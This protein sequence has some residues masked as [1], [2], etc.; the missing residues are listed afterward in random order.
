[1]LNAVFFY[2][3]KFNF[4]MRILFYLGWLLL[5]S[6]FLWWLIFIIVFLGGLARDFNWTYVMTIL[7]QIGVGAYLIKNF[8]S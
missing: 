4:S 3:I 7:I 1:M 2:I 8:N 5:I 6:G